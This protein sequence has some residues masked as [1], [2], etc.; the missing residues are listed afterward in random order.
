[1]FAS[2]NESVKFT[3]SAPVL[4]IKAKPL[5]MLLLL[6]IS[7]AVSLL[8]A[9]TTYY[10]IVRPINLNGAAPTSNTVIVTT[11]KDIIAPTTPNNL[12]VTGTTRSSIS[13]SWDPSSD[14]VGVYKYDVYIDGVKAYITSNTT[15]NISN[16][17]SFKT[18]GLYVIARD[19]TGNQSPKSNQVSASTG[20]QGL[21][22]KYYQGSWNVLPDFNALS[23]FKTGNT[24]NVDISVSTTTTLYGI[25]WEGMIKIPLSGSYTFETSSDDGSKLYIGT[26]SNSATALVNNDGLHGTQSATGTITL[27][28]GNYPIAITY[29]Q[30]G[31]GQA[32]KVYW[33]CIAGGITRQLIPNS[34]FGDSIVIPT[35]SLPIKPSNFVVA[36]NTYNS[37]NLSW[38]DN[39]TNET[40][41][42]LSRSTSLLGE[43]VN[44]GTTVANATSF[45]DTL[46][47]LPATKY[48]Y[49]VRAVD[50]YGQSDYVSTL[51]G[52]WGFN[53]DYND[54]SGNNRNLSATGTPIFSTDKKEGTQSISLNGSSQYLNLPFAT[55][56][57]FPANGY[58]SRSIALWIKPTAGMTAAA[59]TNKVI[60]DFGGADNGMALKFDKGALLA[61]IA[62]NN[63]MS[64]IT[65]ASIA[66]NINWVVS[67]WNHICLVYN[68]TQLQLFLN[69]TLIGTASLSF[70]SVG[71]TTNGSRIG[72]TNGTNAF[73]SASSNYGGLIDDIVILKEPVS[74]TGITAIMNQSYTSDTT[75]ALPA[76]PQAPSNLVSLAKTPTSISLSF[77]DNSVSET[78]FEVFRSFATTNNFRIL[79]TINGGAG[80]IKSFIDSNLFANSNYYYKVRAVGVGGSSDFTSNLLATTANNIPVFTSVDN[81]TMRYDSKK[82]LPISAADLDAGPLVLTFVNALPSFATFTNTTNGNGIISFNPAITDQGVYPIAMQVTDGNQG[83]NT[84][85]FTM[86]VNDNYLPVV[87]ILNDT[88]V[89]EGSKTIINLSAT[90][91]G[92]NASL[93][94]T[95]TSAPSFVSLVD[96]GSGQANLTFAPTYASAGTYPIKILCSD[97]V[98]GDVYSKFTLTVAHVV[99]VSPEKVYISTKNTSPDAPAPWNNISTTSTSGLLNSNGVASSIGIDFLGTPWN[100]GNAGAVTGNNTGIY[101]D[102][103]IKD[104]FWFGTY[105][106]PETVNVNIRGLKLS[107]KYN[108][109]IFGSSAWTGLGNNG[110]TNYSINGVL[111]PLYVDQN[112]HNTVTFSSVIPDTTGIIQLNMSKGLNTPYGLI[113]AIVLERQFDDSTTPVLPGNFAAQALNNGTVKLSWRDLAYNENRYLV[114]RSTIAAGPFTVLNPNASNANDSTYIDSAISSVTTYYYQIEATNSYGSSGLTAVASALTINKA[115]VLTPIT[116]LV[117]KAGTTSIV[118]I[119]STDGPG[120]LI[121]LAATG[122]PSFATFVTTGNGTG[123]I[124]FLPPASTEQGIYKNITV[125]CTDS[126]GASVTDTFN[127]TI[128]EAAL[129]SV[130]VNFGL[131]GGSTQPAPWNNFNFYP[132]ANSSLASLTDDANVNTGFS[133]TLQ[134][135]WQSN[136]SLGMMT[137]DNSGIFPD[138]VLQTSIVS[139]STSALGIQISG[140]DPSKKYNVVFLSSLNAGLSQKVTFSSGAQ[141]VTQE[142]RYNTNLSVQLNGLT[143]DASGTLVVTSTKDVAAAYVNLNA[144]AIQ[145]Y[146]PATPLIKPYYLFAESILDSNK[147]KLTWSDRSDNETGFQVYRSTFLQGPYS[148]VTTTASNVTGYTDS[149]L[150]ANN[151]YYYQVAAINAT[152]TSGYSNIASLVLPYKID[153]INLNSNVSQNGGPKWNN[154][155][156]LN[157]A[158]SLFG[159]LKDNTLTPS[160]IDMTIT[161][162]FNAPGYAGVSTQGVLPGVVM[163]TNYWTDAGMVSEVKF[164]NLDIRKKYKIGCFGSAIHSSYSI[165]VYTCNGKVVQLNSVYNDSKIIYLKDLTSADGDLVVTV[166]TLTGQPYSFTSA[167][168]IESYDDPTPFKSTLFNSVPKTNGSRLSVSN[169][170]QPFNINGQAGLL[171]LVQ[172]PEL[173]NVPEISVFPNPFFNK[174]EVSL[175]NKNAALVTVVLYDLNSKLIYKTAESKQPAGNSTI[176]VNIPSAAILTRGVYVI[177]I[178]VDGKVTKSIKLIK[179]Q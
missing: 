79:Q 43:Y 29:F 88:A 155:L 30:Q 62:S 131:P 103:V 115:P 150:T 50:K 138:N 24:P 132:S 53:N 66:S 130:F 149:G 108:V 173:L 140:L 84:L 71:V 110:T 100:A 147:V 171:S 89:G 165:G 90:K 2:S 112:Q 167:F 163:S 3:T 172:A 78:Y 18:F 143:P 109:T 169:N 37:S 5:P 64:S 129:R 60:Y 59:S 116:D 136:W 14:N 7:K 123:T 120:K 72:A 107:A 92:G 16:L 38:N 152:E 162:D 114:H 42:E 113:N 33:T 39:S 85:S 164:S 125:S 77:N 80:A 177:N 40:G 174:I 161:K 91:Q 98:G 119:V 102:A 55:G 159:N 67:G 124:T 121:T 175:S 74:A 142:A 122:L 70:S 76:I 81:F 94:W 21:N 23:P 104:Y 44:I 106:A 93:A 97:G 36:S 45:V 22:Y 41:F 6:N 65:V 99:P 11:T 4:P 51:N 135:G 9:N 63:V 13:L 127:L 148:L 61:G 145:E 146:N 35:S 1:M 96:N 133:I 25:L 144:M 47:L 46:G 28:A 126:L 52:K 32:M 73:N 178:I 17:D 137:G 134:Q 128:T 156:G 27:T 139:P 87:T 54:G 34:A 179:G 31:G 19:L 58:D 166:T 111:K 176:T 69:G 158:G 15:I 12:I 153:F 101:P 154:T 49:K 141:S 26:Y 168:T 157:T 82:D 118:N 170:M 57:V 8:L 68:I 105:G 86:T 48:W 83:T 75:L 20:L 56:G 160:G 10:Y 117:V 95:L 151:R